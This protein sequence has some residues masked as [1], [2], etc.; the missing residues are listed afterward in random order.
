MLSK[1]LSKFRVR[2]T[3]F[4]SWRKVCFPKDKG[5]LGPRGDGT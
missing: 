2:G 4:T 5:G 1:H 3:S